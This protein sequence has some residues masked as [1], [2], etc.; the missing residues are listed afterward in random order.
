MTN[1]KTNS[2]IQWIAKLS[3]MTVVATGIGLSAVHAE[4][5]TGKREVA[6]YIG[7]YNFV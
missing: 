7:S 5:D 4:D 3:L 2:M 1:S 6:A